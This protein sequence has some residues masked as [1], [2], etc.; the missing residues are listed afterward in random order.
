MIHNHE[1]SITLYDSQ[2]MAQ[3]NTPWFTTTGQHNTPWITPTGSV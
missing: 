3:H 2:P 1:L